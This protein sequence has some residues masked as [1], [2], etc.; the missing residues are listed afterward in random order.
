MVPARPG[1]WEK[2]KNWEEMPLCLK[3]TRFPGPEVSERGTASTAMIRT[4]A[5][6]PGQGQD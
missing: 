2:K 3:P 4:V 5:E 6:D 1:N